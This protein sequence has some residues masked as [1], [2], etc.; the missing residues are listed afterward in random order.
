MFNGIHWIPW[1]NQ[2]NLS[3]RS[4]NKLWQY[5]NE[6]WQSK[7][8]YNYKGSVQ[9]PKLIFIK[10]KKIKM[11]CI[12]IAILKQAISLNAIEVIE[13]ICWGKSSWKQWN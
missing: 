13:C 8:K 9:I 2:Y 6:V 5:Y 7:N 1:I 12:K 10:K 3:I 4:N 11:P